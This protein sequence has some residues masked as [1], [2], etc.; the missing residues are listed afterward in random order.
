MG[1]SL[2]DETGLVGD[3][4]GPKG[5]RLPISPFNVRTFFKRAEGLRIDEI[6]DFLADYFYGR[7]I[8]PDQKDEVIE[9]LAGSLSAQSILDVDRWDLDRL[10]AAVHLILSFAEYQL[11]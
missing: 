9:A 1:M 2:N 7:P 3:S 5:M 6:A 11:C 4:S 8:R 10:R